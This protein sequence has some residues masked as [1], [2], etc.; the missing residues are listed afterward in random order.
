[1]WLP[2][3]HKRGSTRVSFANMSAV[4]YRSPP[5]CRGQSIKGHPCF[6]VRRH[7][8]HVQQNNL[9]S[10]LHR[11]QAGV[12]SDITPCREQHATRRVGGGSLSSRT[13]CRRLPAL[14]DKKT[15]SRW[16]LINHPK[17]RSG[18]LSPPMEVNRG[19]RLHGYWLR[20]AS[21]LE[22]L[23]AWYSNDTVPQIAP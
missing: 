15:F 13:Q 7:R 21:C 12:L 5:S 4:L 16:I 17:S 20:F 10:R 14:G 11:L 3:A 9:S 19:G 18:R 1:V 8:H 6:F 22:A 23:A 2:L